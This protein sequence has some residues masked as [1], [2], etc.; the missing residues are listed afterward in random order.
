MGAFDGG[1]KDGC[2]PR[3]DGCLP[4]IIWRETPIIDATGRRIIGPAE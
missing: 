2:L 4:R 1:P 3:K